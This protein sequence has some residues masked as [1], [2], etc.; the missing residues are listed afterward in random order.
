MEY[1]FKDI[2]YKKD[3][4]YN[5]N[6]KE[7]EILYNNT[8]II[9]S[10][11]YCYSHAIMDFIFPIFWILKDIKKI[12]NNEKFNLFIKR[13]RHP[14]NYK[15][16]NDDDFIGVYKELVDMLNPEKII[17][18]YC[19]TKNF[20]FKNAFE[21]EST[22]EWISNWQRG[23][24]NCSK[25]YPQRNFDIKNVYYTDEIIYKMLNN[26]VN[27]F[28]TKLEINN[29][30]TN[31]NIIIIEREH[32]RKFNGDKLNN[33]ISIIDNKYNFNGIHILDNM[34]LKE[35]IELFS[36]NNIFIFRHGSCLINLL[37]IP[38]NSIV[39]D[40]D[41]V[42][43]RKNIVARICK[44]TNSKHHYLN[45]FNDNIHKIIKDILKY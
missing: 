38:N 15:I 41:N 27:F 19:N 1:K 26:F 23:V 6:I 8:I 11:H 16:I 17:F 21:I 35:Q 20:L 4:Y 32:N 37:W 2:S 45:Y 7:T 14:F 25:Y 3:L 39:I 43:N 44:L 12:N 22:D 9:E 33:I 30:K 18:E 42:D 5:N 40:L 28:K 10:M 34:K 36:K 31:N 13:P 24:W 29:Y